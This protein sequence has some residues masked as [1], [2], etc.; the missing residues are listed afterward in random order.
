MISDWNR[1]IHCER[2]R[3]ESVSIVCCLSDEYRRLLLDRY[4]S[5]FD[6]R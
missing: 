4:S 3:V 6:K 1:V 5:D 2:T